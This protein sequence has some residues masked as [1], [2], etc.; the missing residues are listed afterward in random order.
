MST[1]KAVFKD[2]TATGDLARTPFS[3]IF[4]YI[5]SRNI[6]GTLDLR[7]S[8]NRYL[9]YFIKGM[10]SLSNI[11]SQ[12]VSLTQYLVKRGTITQTELDRIRIRATKEKINEVQA[13]IKLEII[14]PQIILEAQ[15]DLLTMRL[16][17]L[18]GL[19]TAQFGF[20]EDKNLLISD[21][22]R[23]LHPV[24]PLKVLMHGVRTHGAAAQIDPYISGLDNKTI[25]FEKIENIEHL[26]LTPRE[27]DFCRRLVGNPVQNQ[28]LCI[29]DRHKSL[30]LRRLLYVLLITKTVRVISPGE[31]PQDAPKYVSVPPVSRVDERILAPEIRKKR[32][33][34]LRFAQNLMDQNYFEMLNVDSQSD[35]AEIHQAYFAM[36]KRFHPQIAKNENFTDLKS[37]LEYI[38]MNLTEAHTVLSDPDA[39]QGY[40][41][42]IASHTR[43][44]QPHNIFGAQAIISAESAF[45]NA[46]AHFKK[47]EYD[48]ALNFL[49]RALLERPGDPEY[50]A[51]DVWIRSLKR[52]SDADFNDL[53]EKLL[54]AHEKAPHSFAIN[55]YL[56][57]L[58]RR[59]NRSEDATIYLQRA[60]DI[61]P[62]DVEV[63][64]ELK[65]LMQSTVYTQDRDSGS[66]SGLLDVLFGRRKY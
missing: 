55:L 32:Q 26:V 41:M 53:I 27:K 16:A 2:A 24:H 4:V 25:V 1:Q 31:S 11:G 63:A 9:T 45:Q 17:P 39:R 59:I 47:G 60:C 33:Y 15:Q 44:S 54:R 21:G 51:L 19:G 46:K 13:L 36:L 28:E 34:L 61:N 38:S 56:G 58:Y 49:D 7:H 52:N 42:S 65:M 5:W 18:F 30:N 48:H 35:P 6:S 23:H 43:M 66:H 50:I 12:K 10:P 64:R 14:T 57:R 3:H 20:F 40:L 29:G 37:T 62:S 8:K 22:N